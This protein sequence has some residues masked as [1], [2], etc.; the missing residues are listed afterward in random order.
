MPKPMSLSPLLAPAAILLLTVTASAQLHSGM[1]APLPGIPITPPPVD[2]PAL[3]AQP[4][5]NEAVTKASPEPEK[6]DKEPGK[7]AGRKSKDP[8]PA[9]AGPKVAGRD[10]SK[11]VK[12][13]AALKW[14]EKL[15]AAKAHAA[16]ADKPILWLQALGKDIDGFA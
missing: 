9:I 2:H 3:A 1:P 4:L 16:A 11:A 8:D 14:Y 5:F 7:K 12:S 15:P 13:V 6:E 10:L